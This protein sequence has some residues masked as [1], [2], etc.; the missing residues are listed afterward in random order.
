MASFATVQIHQHESHGLGWELSETDGRHFIYPI[1]SS[2]IAHML[3]C[4]TR[5]TA[6]AEDYRRR[7]WVQA[8][9]LNGMSTH[10]SEGYYICTD[11]YSD[12]LL[13]LPE[14]DVR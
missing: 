9:K 6:D 11:G 4:V 12:G 7:N 1:F 8:G 2:S 3:T 14:G 5:A 10:S 13:G